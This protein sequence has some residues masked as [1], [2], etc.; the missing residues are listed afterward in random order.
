MGLL[1][2]ESLHPLITDITK[3]DTFFNMKRVPVA[4]FK[5][6]IFSFI[7]PNA[8]KKYFCGQQQ[9]TCYKFYSSL[10]QAKREL[11]DG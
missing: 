6:Q 4:N 11:G 2:F 8:L 3:T 5:S 9:L 1:L 7:P 10:H